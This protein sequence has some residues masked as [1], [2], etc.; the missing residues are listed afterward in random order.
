[1]SRRMPLFL[2]LVMGLGWVAGG[3]VAII[4]VG[5]LA[6]ASGD[7][8]PYTVNGAR[9]SKEEFMAFALPFLGGYLGL[10]LMLIGTSLGLHRGRAWSRPLLF[11]LVLGSVSIGVAAALLAGIPLRQ[12]APGSLMGG[13]MLASLWWYLYRDD[14]VVGYYDSLP[15]GPETG[16]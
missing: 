3:G 14:A 9:V 10:C 2:R 4:I 5:F 7:I 13:L 16:S 15:V 1:M 11:S 12:G 8:G 6:L